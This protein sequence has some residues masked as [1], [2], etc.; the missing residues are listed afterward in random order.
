MA[1]S[2]P[3]ETLM[4]SRGIDRAATL[5]RRDMALEIMATTQGNMGLLRGHGGF[6]VRGGERW[7]PYRTLLLAGDYIS[8]ISRH[9]SSRRFSPGPWCH[10]VALNEDVPSPRSTFLSDTAIISLNHYCTQLSFPGPPK[11]HSEHTASKLDNAIEWQMPRNSP[12]SLW[13]WNKVGPDGRMTSHCCSWRD[14]YDPD[15]T[16]G[17]G[18]LE[19]STWEDTHMETL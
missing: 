9:I 7:H 2:L 6:G 11:H 14:K 10:F 3:R 12:H 8:S 17:T 13:G 19:R 1:V 5:P 18:N 15:K 4:E 16:T